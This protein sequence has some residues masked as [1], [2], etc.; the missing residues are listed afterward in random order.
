MNMVLKS[1]H[2]SNLILPIEEIVVASHMKFG[3]KPS[4]LWAMANELKWDYGTSLGLWAY[5]IL[6]D[7]GEGGSIF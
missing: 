2:K 3:L 1:Q 5:Q 6:T 4:L 7:S